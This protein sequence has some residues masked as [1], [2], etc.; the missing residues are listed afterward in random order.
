[1]AAAT[2]GSWP[3][4]ASHRVSA[5]FTTAT[6]VLRFPALT[7]SLMEGGRRIKNIAKNVCV[8]TDSWREMLFEFPHESTRLEAL[9]FHGETKQDK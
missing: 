7:A 8:W 9:H 2:V 4:R 5:V 6:A 1:M 3:P